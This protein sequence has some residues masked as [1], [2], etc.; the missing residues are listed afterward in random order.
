[1]AAD[2][3]ATMTSCGD[4]FGRLRTADE[5]YESTWGVMYDAA[6]GEGPYQLL[7]DPPGSLL[8]PARPESPV[9][10]H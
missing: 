5:L 2:T 1:M 8:L 9:M 10:V 7:A 4:D 6:G 3:Y